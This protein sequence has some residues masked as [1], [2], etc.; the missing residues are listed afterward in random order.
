MKIV[1][2]SGTA[3]ASRQRY[4]NQQRKKPPVG[5]MADA[6]VGSAPLEPLTRVYCMNTVQLISSFHASAALLDNVV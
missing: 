2:A 3:V 6:G 4:R 5:R 1:D